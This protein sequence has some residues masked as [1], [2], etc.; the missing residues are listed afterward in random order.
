MSEESRQRLIIFTRYPEAVTTKT[1]LIPDIG[2]TGATAVYRYCLEYTLEV[3]KQSGLEYQIFL[4]E[5]CDDALFLQEEHC[6]QKG[7]DLGQRLGH[8]SMP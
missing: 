8:M 1:R 5:D 7:E 2:A 6:L 3:V 4:S